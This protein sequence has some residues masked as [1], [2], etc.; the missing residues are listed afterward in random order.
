MKRKTAVFVAVKAFVECDGKI[1]ILRESERYNEGTRRGEWDIPGGR[2]ATGENLEDALVREVREETGLNIASC[3]PFFADETTPRPVVNNEE[4]QIIRI[5]FA[6][7]ADT[8]SVVLSND[9]DKCAW[10][11][12]N[13]YEGGVI[14]NLHGAFEAYRMRLD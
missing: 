6:C 11:A 5:F 9:H 1:L 7:R 10:I 14:E 8:S 2:I 3:T 4:W 12:P 13:K